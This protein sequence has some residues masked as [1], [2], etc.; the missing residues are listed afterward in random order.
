MH[1]LLR[2]A[3]SLALFLILAAFGPQALADPPLRV[4]RLSYVNGPV[5]FNA[6]GTDDWVVAPLN[7]PVVYGDQ[8]WADADARG[9]LALGHA[10]LWLGPRT[11]VRVLDLDDRTAQLEVAQGTVALR[12]RRLSR[13]ETLE[14]DTP[15]LAFVVTQPGRYRV[16]VDEQGDATLVAVRDGQAEVYGGSSSYVVARGQTYRFGGTDLTD[17]ERLPPPA[18]DAF[19]RFAQERDRRFEGVAS[20]RYV[21]DEVIGY[22]DLDRYGTWSTVPEYGNVWYPREVSASWVPYREGHWS[23]VDPWGWTWVDDAPW[24]FAPFHYGRWIY[25]RDR[26]GWVPGPSNVRPVYGPAFVAFVDAGNVRV[27]G[28]GGGPAIGWFPLGPREV[29][30]PSY[31]ASAQYVRQVNVSNTVITNVTVL[32]N[33]IANPAAPQVNTY[34]NLRAPNAVTAVPPAAMAQAQSVTRIAR[35]IPGNAIEASHIQ[36]YAR[37]APAAQA[38]VG[39]ARPA[40]AKPPVQVETRPVVARNAPP[41]PPTPVSQRLPMLQQNPGK[42]VEVRTAAP[43]APAATGPRPVPG[44]AAATLAVP[45][46]NV[47]VVNVPKPAATAAPPARTPDAGHANI[48]RTSPGTP[49]TAPAP[50]GAN[51]ATRAT[52]PPGRPDN[53]AENPRGQGP[54]PGRPPERAPANAPAATVPGPTPPA[55]PTA[56]ERAA[57]PRPADGPP[58]AAPPAPAPGSPAHRDGAASGSAAG[59]PGVRP[60]PAARPSVTPPPPVAPGVSPVAPPRGQAEPPK[61]PPGRER[62]TDTPQ[63]PELLPRT[64]APPA[65]RA[66]PVA[67]PPPPVPQAAPARPPETRAPPPPVPQPAPARPPETRVPP[68][69]AAPAAAAPRA[70]EARPPAVASPPPAAPAARPPEPRPS[71]AAAPQPAG[72]PP[73]AG[74]PPHPPESRPP[75]P[76]RPAEKGPPDKAPPGQAD[77]KD[78]RDKKEK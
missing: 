30:R 9:E 75:P 61:A 12:V 14:I 59:G 4:L 5:S 7:R 54:A 48:P 36:P 1:S 74:P 52:P 22:E 13:D 16:S 64:P 63:G 47:R 44:S 65:P 62:A 34:V 49:D 51:P 24:G 39:P 72:P 58:P 15:N 2:A 33:I 29:Y 67:P 78:N 76:N 20:A 57:G 66:A 28:G 45:P 31:A 27:S 73:G 77:G 17:S 50:A 3:L 56:S 11:S 21:S 42:P 41:P 40:Q 69:A 70:P 35:V 46:S 53:A 60:P 43:P 10:T 18:F 26:W 55:A 37:V 38:M 19:E 71:P 68:A 6:A 8:L 23:W 25:A 32:N